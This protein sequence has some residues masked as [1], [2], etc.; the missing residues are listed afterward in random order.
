MK[1]DGRGEG[2]PGVDGAGLGHGLDGFTDGDGIGRG[3]GLLPNGDGLGCGAAF[4]GRENGE[5]ASYPTP[6]VAQ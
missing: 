1:H 4:G 3:R 2:H 6:E 5:G